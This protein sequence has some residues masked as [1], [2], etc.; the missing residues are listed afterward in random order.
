MMRLLILFAMAA[1]A[2]GANVCPTPEHNGDITA[3]SEFSY[4]NT[5]GNSNTTSLAFEG[6]AK[7]KWDFHIFRAHLDAYRSSNNG[8]TSKNKWSSELNYDYQFDEFISTNY[9]AGYREDRFSR[10]DYQLYT[11]PGLG[12]KVINETD[13]KLSFQG[14][15]L[16]AEDKPQELPKD[17]YLSSKLGFDYQWKVLENLKFIQEANYRLNMEE[18]KYW[19]AYSKTAIESKINA[20]LSMG[21]SY[22]IDYVNTP[23]PTTISHTDKTFLVSLIIDY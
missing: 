14:N 6:N 2:M 15:L 19:F 16:F 3:H 20:S 4:I 23:P 13:E 12:L 21:M 9:L 8:Q 1:S 10:F 7:T 18:T 17:D 11:G 22:K 5:K